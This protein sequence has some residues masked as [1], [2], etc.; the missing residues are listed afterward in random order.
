MNTFT[1][2]YPNSN[3]CVLY[4]KDTTNRLSINALDTK[5]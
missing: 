1:I 3:I 2:D 5:N 4:K